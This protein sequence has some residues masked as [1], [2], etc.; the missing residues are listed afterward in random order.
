MEEYRGELLAPAGTMDCLKAAIAAGA[1]AVYL[2]GQRFGARAFAGCAQ[3]EELTL[4]DSLTTIGEG[5]LDGLTGLKKLVVKCDPALIPA[6][7]FA[8]MPNLSEVTIESGAV[9]AHMFEGSG[10]TALTLGAGVTEIGES[11]FAGTALSA[12]ELTHI[13]VI[14][15][16]AFA[17]TALSAADLTNATAV[18]AGA[19]GLS[20]GEPEYRGSGV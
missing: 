5:A 7:V 12:A 20:V 6:G 18:G 9:P 16:K 8:N 19:F 1:D 15:E 10:V 4:P 14:G 3:L 13:T 2:G 11:A 17:G